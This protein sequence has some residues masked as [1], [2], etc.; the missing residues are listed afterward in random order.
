MQI[1]VPSFKIVLARASLRHTFVC[2]IA[3]PSALRSIRP[4]T[5]RS[6]TRPHFRPFA[7]PPAI[8]P[9]V[10][11]SLDCPPHVRLSALSGVRQTHLH[12]ASQRPPC[13]AVTRILICNL[14]LPR[15]LM[16]FIFFQSELITSLF[17]C[18]IIPYHSYH[19]L[20]PL[21]T[22]YH[23]LSPPLS[24]HLSLLPFCFL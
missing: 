15:R 17:S 18:F 14:M 12:K 3:C 9:A 16:Y 13:A 23:P 5:R 2:P 7:C 6:T 10:R 24:S 4:S 20:S 22:S 11:R 1:V 19:L 21:I 8:R